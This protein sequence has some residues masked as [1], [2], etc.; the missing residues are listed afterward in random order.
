MSWCVC[1]AGGVNLPRLRAKDTAEGS[2]D[3][4]GGSVVSHKHPENK[5]RIRNIFGK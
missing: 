2:A 1:A 5:I 4:E 3:P